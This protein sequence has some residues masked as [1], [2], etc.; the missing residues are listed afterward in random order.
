MHYLSLTRDRQSAVKVDCNWS[1]T[2]E[3]NHSNLTDAYTV[4]V[5]SILFANAN[6]D[7]NSH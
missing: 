5:A 4:M 2:Q 3:V 6:N 1:E 7:Q